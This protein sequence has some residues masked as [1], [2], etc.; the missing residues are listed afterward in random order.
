MIGEQA[1]EEGVGGGL[2]VEG[3]ELARGDGLA[4]QGLDEDM[5]GAGRVEG[6]GGARRRSGYAAMAP[7]R[8]TPRLRDGGGCGRPVPRRGSRRGGWRGGARRLTSPADTG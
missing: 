6:Q 7:P 4:E 8:L 2:G 1:V 5:G 3:G